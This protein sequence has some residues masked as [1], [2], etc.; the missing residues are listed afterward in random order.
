M[1]YIYLRWWG[2][3]STILKIIRLSLGWAL[4]GS[5]LRVSA[6]CMLTLCTSTPEILRRILYDLYSVVT[7]KY[8]IGSVSG[9]VNNAFRFSVPAL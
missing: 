1:Y 6:R 9:Y 2:A 3:E 7:R 8:L 4:K 5:W